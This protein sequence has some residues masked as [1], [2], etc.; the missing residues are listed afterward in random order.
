MPAKFLRSILITGGT[1]GLGYHCA[2]NV[3][4]KYPDYQIIIASRSDPNSSANALNNALNQKNVRFLPLDLSSL[5]QWETNQ[6]PPIHSLVFNAAL[7]FPGDVQYSID[8]FEKTFAISHIGHALLFSLLRPHL[9]DMARVVIVSSG[10]HDP[11]Q[12][13]GMPDAYY[14]SA[15]ELAHPTGQSLKNNGRQRYSTTKLVNVLYGY[16]LHRRFEA[17][18]KKSGKHW[19][20]AAFDPGFMPGTGLARD[21]SALQRF[22][23]LK[24]LPKILPLLRLLL[25]PNTHT[26][27][28]SGK[29]LARLVIESDEEIGSGAYYE[30]PK[31]IKSSDAS[32]DQDKQEC[33]GRSRP[34][35]NFISKRSSID[36]EN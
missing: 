15:G 35:N 25:T 26:V 34:R 13:S 24:V 17:I 11:A 3:A 16:A 18:N 19:T 20:V 2:L 28:H 5:A 1:S 6:F 27:E 33:D 22:L 10:T 31:R 36:E 29:M 8:G 12:K 21:Y 4:R 32:Y 7:Q 23:W 14:S 30:G 9:A